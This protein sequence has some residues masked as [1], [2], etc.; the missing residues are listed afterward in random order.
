[1]DERIRKSRKQERDGA[2]RFGGTVNSQSGAGWVRK[3]DVTTPTES[4]EFKYTDK[5]SY[6]LKLED[7][8]TAWQHATSAGKRMVFAIEFGTGRTSKRYV[9]L[10]EDDYLADQEELKE[11]LAEV[12]KLWH[13]IETEHGL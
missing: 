5:R 8:K 9:V 4:I 7:L 1:M 13:L 11:L 10:E 2:T 6:S 3:N 12:E